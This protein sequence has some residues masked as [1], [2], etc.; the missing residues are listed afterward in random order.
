MISC[1]RELAHLKACP[2]TRLRK[3][4]WHTWIGEVSGRGAPTTAGESPALQSF[5]G[6]LDG[7]AH[8]TESN[9][10]GK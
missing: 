10:I 4:V 6:G 2:D 1:S 7:E 8:R 3:H 9:D 5:A